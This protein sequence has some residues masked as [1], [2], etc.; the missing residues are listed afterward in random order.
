MTNLLPIKEGCTALVIGDTIKGNCGE[1]RVGKNLG[2]VV[3]AHPDFEV[4][5][6]PACDIWE[7]NRELVWRSSADGILYSFKLCP[8]VHLLRIDGGEFEKEKEREVVL[9]GGEQR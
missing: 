5:V 3:D 6:N 4:E 8:E 9:V 1:I 7:V 2:P